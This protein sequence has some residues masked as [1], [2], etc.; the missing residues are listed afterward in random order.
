MKEG[1]NL[2]L[3]PTLKTALRD[4]EICSYGGG[5]GGGNPGDSR[6][7]RWAASSLK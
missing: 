7:G 4:P 5:D 2:S 1:V 6:N 3:L